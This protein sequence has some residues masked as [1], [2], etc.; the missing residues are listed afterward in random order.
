MRFEVGT[1]R[2]IQNQV[3][4]DVT[5]YYWLVVPDIS[6]KL[7][8]CWFKISETPNQVTQHHTTENLKNSLITFLLYIHYFVLLKLI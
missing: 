6:K 7:P 3:F 8:P 4:W 1:V 2:H 5:L